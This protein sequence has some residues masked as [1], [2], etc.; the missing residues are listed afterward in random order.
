M[1]NHSTCLKNK[2]I[3]K[4]AIRHFIGHSNSLRS[5]LK[6]QEALTALLATPRGVLSY[7]RDISDG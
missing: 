6:V 3:K 7:G 5:L 2:G 4:F 1:H